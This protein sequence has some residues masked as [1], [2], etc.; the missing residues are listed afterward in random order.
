MK[1]EENAKEN[2]RRLKRAFAASHTYRNVFVVLHVHKK[3]HTLYLT[4]Y[5]IWYLSHVRK[6]LQ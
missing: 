3:G 6:N 4:A 1:K 2:S 5:Q